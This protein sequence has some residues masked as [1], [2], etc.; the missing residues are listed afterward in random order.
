[1]AGSVGI[2]L[3]TI[4]HNFED[5][6]A[7]DTARV[8]HY[9]AALEG[10]SMLVLPRILNWFTADIA[11]HHLHHLSVAIPNYQLAACHHKYESLFTDIK[12]F[13]VGDLLGTFEY[14]LWD[15][16]EQKVVARETTVA[17]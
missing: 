3:F 9:K 5:S 12:R 17:L 8:C 6:Y 14:Q 2:L 15:V 13:G 7:T 11:Y 1:L 4:Q 10:T 16:E